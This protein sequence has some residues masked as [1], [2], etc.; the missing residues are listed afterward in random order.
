MPPDFR[1]SVAPAL[2]KYEICR[3]RYLQQLLRTAAQS[4]RTDIL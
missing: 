3:L 4:C 1:R 2:N